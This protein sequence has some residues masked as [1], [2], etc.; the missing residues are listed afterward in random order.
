[1]WRLQAQKLSRGQVEKEGGETRKRNR[2]GNR[3]DYWDGCPSTP[4]PFPI[5][6]SKKRD[7]KQ[8]K[9]TGQKHRGGHK[10]PGPYETGIRYSRSRYEMTCVE[11]RHETEPKEKGKAVQ[12]AINNHAEVSSP[13]IGSRDCTCQSGPGHKPLPCGGKI[14]QMLR[15]TPQVETESLPVRCVQSN[16]GIQLSGPNGR[17]RIGM[18]TLRRK[19][20]TIAAYENPYSWKST[21]HAR[22]HQ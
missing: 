7:S 16:Y 6:A 5:P 4:P 19:G 8:K 20:W 3:T 11:P 21:S 13:W 10:K 14:G 22:I 9:S 17:Y 12:G 15:H 18:L 2:H 1:V